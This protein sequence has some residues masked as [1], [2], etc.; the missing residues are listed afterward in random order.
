VIYDRRGRGKSKGNSEDILPIQTLA[1]DAVAGVDYLKSRADVKQIG[2]YGL[3][4]GGWVAPL[5]VTISPDISFLITISAPS[6]TPNEQNDYV[7]ANISGKYIRSALV[8]SKVPSEIIDDIVNTHIENYEATR[9]E[10]KKKNN[11][12][13][14][15]PGFSSFDPINTWQ[16]IKIPVLAVWGSDDRLIPALKSKELIEEALKTAENKDYNLKIFP[17][18]NHS[19]RLSSDKEKFN[20]RWQLMVPGSQKFIVSWTKEHVK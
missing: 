1:S 8:K 11:N 16:K 20:G 5:A 3:S 4:Q 9:M 13:E 19:I 12:E 14:E 10:L 6:I 15:V 18:A 2:I 17:G 7:M